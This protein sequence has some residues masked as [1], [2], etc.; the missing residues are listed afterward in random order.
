MTREEILQKIARAT[1]IDLI[2]QRE[3]TETQFA[4]VLEVVELS[5]DLAEENTI[6]AIKD[7]VGGEL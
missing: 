3:L 7:R 2:L 5:M 4:L 6:K 1:A